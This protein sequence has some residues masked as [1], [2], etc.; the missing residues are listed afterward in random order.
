M[1]SI[2]DNDRLSG[3][4]ASSMRADLLILLSDVDGELCGLLAGLY[5]VY[6]L[7]AVPGLFTGHP[8]DSGSRL[9][10]TY[11]PEHATEVS[12]WGKSHVGLGGMENKV[13]SC[14]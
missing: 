14:P 2:P 1:A 11:H 10:K 12:F 6:C 9:I 4:V 3:L 8:E 13:T 5:V 7:P